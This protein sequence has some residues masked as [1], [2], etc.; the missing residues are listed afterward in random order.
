MNAK[1][2]NNIVTYI[3]VTDTVMIVDWKYLFIFIAI[4]CVSTAV[5]GRRKG[6]S[7]CYNIV[8][9]NAFHFV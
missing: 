2:S 8:C 1:V 9:A 5:H 6:I 4:V 7:K 3:E